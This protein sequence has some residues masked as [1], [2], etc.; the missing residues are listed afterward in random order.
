MRIQPHLGA[1]NA[2]ETVG[3]DVHPMRGADHD[4]LAT[5]R[6]IALK[7]CRAVDCADGCAVHVALCGWSHDATRAARNASDVTSAKA[8]ASQRR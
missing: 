3:V 2:L 8:N 4:P 1:V 7:A 6:A 5:V